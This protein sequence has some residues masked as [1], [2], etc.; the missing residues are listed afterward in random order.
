MPICCA[1]ACTRDTRLSHKSVIRH[2]KLPSAV[3]ALG[4]PPRSRS[5]FLRLGAQLRPLL[6][7]ASAT[8]PTRPIPTVVLAQTSAGIRTTLARVRRQCFRHGESARWKMSSYV[9]IPASLGFELMCF[10]SPTVRIR[11]CSSGLLPQRRRRY[12]QLS[13]P[14]LRRGWGYFGRGA[15]CEHAPVVSHPAPPS[16]L[17]PSRGD[18]PGGVSGAICEREGGELRRAASP[19]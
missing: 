11:V 18:R 1:R 6:R 13:C 3:A 4:S 14:K 2:N 7:P 16:P 9:R 17:N 19:P 12:R 10:S 15:R 8:W 5:L